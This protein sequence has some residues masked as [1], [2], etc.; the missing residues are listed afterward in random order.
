V[1]Q[2]DNLYATP[3]A[4]LETSSGE[5]VA[6]LPPE[7]EREP[8]GWTPVRRLAVSG[9][10]FFVLVLLALVKIPC[11]RWVG[12]SVMGTSPYE[13]S[14]YIPIFN[15]GFMAI[16]GSYLLIEILSYRI[17]AWKELRSKGME[18]RRTLDRLASHLSIVLAAI[19]AA[20]TVSD[21][22]HIGA[23]SKEPV[24][25]FAMVV[26]L[27][28]PVLLFLWAMRTV[29][30]WGLGRGAS[31]LVAAL[32][33]GE[34][35]Q[36]IQAAP[37]LFPGMDHRP[38]GLYLMVL[39]FFAILLP[40]FL[41]KML[42]KAEPEA[43]PWS[44]P[45]PMSGLQPLLIPAFL[46]H[47]GILMS[48]EGVSRQWAPRA[49]FGAAPNFFS[50]SQ[51]GWIVI[52]FAILLALAFNWPARV[53]AP[54]RR[55]Q[56]MDANSSQNLANRMWMRGLIPTAILLG[57]L[58]TLDPV[59]SAGPRPVYL[60]SLT[61]FSFIGTDLVMEWQFRQQSGALARVWKLQYVADVLP[62]RHAMNEASIP[63]FATGYH[64]RSLIQWL[65]I[66][67]PVTILVPASKAE[68]AQ[69]RIQE[70]LNP[71]S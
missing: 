15:A 68:E 48:M 28:A 22:R 60:L 20:M 70:L 30:R 2:E 4:D 67:V 46:S 66:F 37:R 25:F 32:L 11:I 54:W 65:G 62:I 51:A 29:D 44:L 18:G 55:I 69:I 38:P 24:L 13:I 63:V 16:P 23:I 49:L 61:F 40:F 1:T 41:A 52:I 31:V 71:G 6:I 64:H 7:V 27:M 59:M 12:A 26:F 34:M 21:L 3:K 17:A 50:N 19:E 8:E 5:A 47:F 10:I 9:G 45:I 14:T 56:G 43:R 33:L 39:I 58:S 36:S 42:Q 57:V 53:A 35:I